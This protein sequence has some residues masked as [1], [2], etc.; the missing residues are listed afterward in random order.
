MNIDQER[1]NS[2]RIQ[3]SRQAKLDFNTK[4]YEEGLIQN[5]SLTGMFVQGDF[6]ENEGDHCVVNL[7]QK[8]KYSCLSLEASAQVVRKDDKGV[9]ITFTSMPLNSLMH[10]QM[11][12]HC[13][14]G[15][16]SLSSGIESLDNL[17]FEVHDG[18][19]R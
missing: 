8:G 3:P 17:P 7:S 2:P 6:Q 18:L 10:L 11:I 16:D 1:R 12:L 9:A 14:A 5:F 4:V 13:E 15:A 19:L